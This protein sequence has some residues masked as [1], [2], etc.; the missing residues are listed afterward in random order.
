[1]R[2]Y[3]VVIVGSGFGGSIS[4]LRLAQAGKSVAVL[5]RGRRYRAGS[6]PRDIAKLDELFWRRQSR[7]Q[8]QGLYD[9]RFL[10]GV[11][12]LTASGVGGGS[13]IYANVH[14]R[15]HPVVFEDPGWP[16][17]YDRATL[18]PYFDKVATEL[19]LE[20]VP[21]A[22]RL[23]KRDAFN[24]AAAAMH[25]P[26]FDPP[27]A[28]SFTKPPAPDRK[29]CQLVAEC[30]FG[31]QH[32]AK[33]SMD[34][35]Y[36]A[37]AESLGATVWPRTNV[38][39]IEPSS[40]GY[41]VHYDD[42]A[43]G[44]RRCVR[45]I[46]VVLAAG[47][48]SSVEILLRSRD[49]AGTLPRVSARLGHGYS[50]NGD[51][52][53]SLQNCREDL[54]PWLGP[55]VTTVMSFFDADPSFTL[56]TPTFSRAATEVLASL[57]QPKL[58][59]FGGVGTHLWPV[60]GPVLRSAMSRGL[61]SKPL[62]KGAVNPAGFCNLFAIGRDNANGR[63]RLKGERLDIAWDYAK[64]NALLVERMSLAMESL[65]AQYGGTFAPLFTWPLFRRPLTVHSL[66]GAHL[67]ESPA[68]GVVS[69]EGEV[70]GYPGLYV[71]DGSVIPTS[72]G[73]HPA[74][75]ISAVAERI[76]EAMTRSS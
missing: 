73:F 75:T 24:R 48:L 41:R 66:G 38:T 71:T 68:G 57:G 22:L 28:V 20:P 36:L 23:H 72:L 3:D 35:S 60:V 54:Q 47:T 45:G 67:A 69:T 1:M 5:E 61:L 51:F 63:M 14:V 21:P 12:T 30:E 58:G 44:G 10:T 15:P 34:L 62:G 52:L 4:A 8:A 50:A 25:V 29:V 40:G 37:R 7:P 43:G 42:L 76:A 46:R 53:G 9:L 74:M 39:H 18:E 65:A 64:E 16:R 2:T 33:N 19:Q 27:L 31:C 70:F 26:T 6:F 56:V 13:L 49:I 11:G 17:G 32:G 59:I 55:D